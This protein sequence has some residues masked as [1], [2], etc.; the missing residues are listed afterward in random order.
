MGHVRDAL[1]QI[2]LKLREDALRDKEG[3]QNVSK[4]SNPAI[5]PVDPLYTSALPTILSGMP[6]VAPLSYESRVEAERELTVFSGGS[7]YG[8]SS[9]QVHRVMLFWLFLNFLELTYLI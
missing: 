7:L 9:L 2:V 4:D 6:P 1:V 8:Y 5:P 3:S